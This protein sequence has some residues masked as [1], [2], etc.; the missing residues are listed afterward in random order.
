MLKQT[1]LY[2]QHQHAGAQIVDF[3]GWEMPLHYG[4]QL[5]EHHHVRGSVGMFDVSHLCIIDLIGDD[6]Y[7]FLRY[8]LANDIAR[9]SNV[10]SA[11][12]TCLLNQAGGVL[13]D[14]V[15]YRID[16]YDY[17]LVVNAVTRDKVIAWLQK[18]TDRYDVRLQVRDDLAIL[19]LQ[20]PD[21]ISHLLGV[22]EDAVLAEQLP[23]T[24]PFHFIQFNQ[25]LMA[26]TGYTG[27]DG[28]EIILPKDKLEWLWKQ[29][30][31]RGVKPCGLG[32][33]DTLRLEA[34]LNVYG[35]DMTEQTSP[36]ESNLTNTV[37]WAD[38]SRDFIGKAALQQQLQQG[39][40]RR[41]IGLGMQSDGMLRNHQKV[42][43]ANGQT[44]EIT[45]GGFSPTL[46]H[47]I[48]LAR[49]PVDVITELFVESRGKRV[50]V[51]RINPPF[52]QHIKRK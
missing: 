32:A 49:V 51:Q 21:A 27:E 1:P 38:A 2:D 50:A 10:G 33:R 18:H 28:F 4:S 45:S 11:L 39:L 35:V 41:L 42:Y 40:T 14:M 47:A 44:G 29:L 23:S 15:V 16:H 9:L 6:T 20:G 8:L 3:C 19:A 12:Y 5:Q 52:I 34:G 13:G 22:M 25:M 17:R 36:L 7:Y 43:L 37:S 30:L 46:G 26:R 24:R 31:R 48:A